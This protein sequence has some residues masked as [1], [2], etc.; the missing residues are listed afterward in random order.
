[1]AFAGA[2]SCLGATPANGCAATS[3]LVVLSDGEQHQLPS[4]RSDHGTCRQ[5][6]IVEEGFRGAAN[7]EVTG[8][9]SGSGFV[10]GVLWKKERRELRQS[11]IGHRTVQ[12]SVA[13]RTRDFSTLL[14][15]HAEPDS[16][17]LGSYRENRPG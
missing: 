8:E 3:P 16:T 13:D 5:G 6:F 4:G 14:R 15:R 11:R 7:F 10:R 1:L 12:H 9:Y 2:L 17:A